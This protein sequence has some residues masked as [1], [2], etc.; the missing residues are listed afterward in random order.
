MLEA[1]GPPW[2]VR[3]DTATECILWRPTTLRELG[4]NER[5]LEELIAANP[6]I[7]GLEDRRTNVRGPYKSRDPIRVTVTGMLD[8]STAA[9]T[10]IPP[11][12]SRS[13]P[14]SRGRAS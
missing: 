9:R 7:L 5:F 13:P 8:C 4:R 10:R 2:L 14:R 12:G 11:F 6:A 3:G 1:G